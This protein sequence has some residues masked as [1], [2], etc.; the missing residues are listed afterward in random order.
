MLRACELFRD[1][2]C[3][4]ITK[5]DSDDTTNCAQQ[6]THTTKHIVITPEHWD[7]GACDTADERAK[8]NKKFIHNLFS[9]HLK[10][11]YLT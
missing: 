6:N 9:I 4:L 2:L 3:E 10:N 8:S 7:I 5:D 11:A 1:S